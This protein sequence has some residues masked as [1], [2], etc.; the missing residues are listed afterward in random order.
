[1]SADRDSS[2]S[3]PLDG[4]GRRPEPVEGAG[5]GG[6]L[7][8]WV[9]PHLLK[10]PGYVPIEPPDVL[11]ERIGLPVEAIVKLD[12]NEN[13]YG[14]SP[15]TLAALAGA[16]G[17][18]IYPDPEQRRLRA[19][20]GE[21]AGLGADHIVAGAGSD[22]LIDL[23]TRMFVAPGDA[24]LNFPPTFG[25]YA[26]SAEVQ[27]ARVINLPR[28]HDFTLK[29]DGFADQARKARLIFVVSP[30]NPSGT[31]LAAEELGVLL[32]TGRPVVVDEAYAEF[33]GESYARL[34]PN[35][36]NL[37]VLRTM[38][39]WAGLAG[40]R[41][42][43]MVASP[44]I[45]EVALKAKQPYSVS[46]A[47]ETAALASLQDREWLMAN[48]A[49][50]VQERERLGF[51]AG[52]AAWL[53]GRALAGELH[54]LPAGSPGREGLA[55]QAGEQRDHDPILR[56]AAVAELRAHQRR[57]ARTYGTPD[58]GAA[59]DHGN[60]H[61]SEDAAEAFRPPGAGRGRAAA[62]MGPR[63]RRRGRRKKA[64]PYMTLT[65]DRKASYRR[66]TRETSIEVVW[67]LD[68]SGVSDVSTGIGMLDHLID[69]LARH[70]LFDITVKATG[71]L[72]I[73]PHHTMEDVGIALGRA[74][75]EAVG[76][77]TGIVRMGDALVPLD[78]TLVQVAVDVSG[79]GYA[80]VNC[81]WTGTSVGDIPADLVEHFLQSLAREGKF[82][83][84]VRLVAGVNDHHKAEAIFKA[85]ARAL[86]AATRPDPRRAGQTPSTKGAIG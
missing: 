72:H 75:A 20:L 31:P 45:T 51:G 5:G 2:A 37:M 43:Y 84:H 66:E 58:G 12:G 11:A 39:K 68:G 34:V 3:P 78:E 7:R 53:G 67:D 77:A 41:V 64:W 69:Q 73:D 10:I 29:L 27:G 32:Q 26:F 42:G 56:Y 1:M 82:N 74:F 50:L 63:P 14:P 60:A 71:D 55:R 9:Q 24:I 22:E 79:R 18:N 83:L 40:L 59:G 4:G 62:A 36:P 17:Y 19:G 30:N 6:W 49:K 54:P 8:R 28:R 47:A 25:M 15:R 44:E 16:H 70:G 52:E 86:C 35:H 13:P 76:D 21:Y 57:Q 48:V 85:L 81:P 65:A 61:Q 33:A 80:S 46:V 23:A 38:S